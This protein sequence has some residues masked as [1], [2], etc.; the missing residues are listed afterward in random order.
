M[1]FDKSVYADFFSGLS[2][3][4]WTYSEFWQNLGSFADNIISLNLKGWRPEVEIVTFG[5]VCAKSMHP[6]S[7]ALTIKDFDPI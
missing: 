7:G 4:L 1:T 6:R 2:L 5:Q 3:G